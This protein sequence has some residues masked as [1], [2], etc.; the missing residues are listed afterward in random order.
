MPD[1]ISRVK[2]YVRTVAILDVYPEM[3]WKKKME[4]K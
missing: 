3:E 2:F 4:I 1:T